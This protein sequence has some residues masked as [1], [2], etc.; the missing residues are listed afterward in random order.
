[1]LYKNMGFLTLRKRPRHEWPWVQVEFWIHSITWN[2]WF[3]CCCSSLSGFSWRPYHFLV[4]L[5]CFECCISCIRRWSR[6]HSK[7]LYLFWKAFDT[8]ILTVEFSQLKFSVHMEY[9]IIFPNRSIYKDFL[10][11][12]GF[13]NIK[14]NHIG[15]IKIIN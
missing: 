9:G 12:S 14:P 15:L 13:L 8:H 1:M 7:H 10:R 4:V 6:D 2:H 3:S 5:N 11:L